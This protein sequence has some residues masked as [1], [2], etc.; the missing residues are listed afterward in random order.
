M[1]ALSRKEKTMA[2]CRHGDD[3]DLYM[4]KTFTDSYH[5]SISRKNSLGK[6][7]LDFSV[8]TSNQALRRMKRM[9]TQG[10]KVPQYAID[11]LSEEINS[12]P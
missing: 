9:K 5:F 1:T 6:E 2:Y 12:S 8:L 11:R 4:F 7:A 10:F 3:S